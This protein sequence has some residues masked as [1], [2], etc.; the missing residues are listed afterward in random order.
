VLALRPIHVAVD[1]ECLLVAEQ[2]GKTDRPTLAFE[3]VILKYRAT[4]RQRTPLL[5]NPLDVTPQ[6][7]LLRKELVARPAVF[8]ALVRKANPI[9]PRQVGGCGECLVGRHNRSPLVYCGS[10][11]CR[12][13]PAETNIAPL[14]DL[15]FN[16]AT[17]WC[18]VR[19]RPSEM[20]LDFDDLAIPHRQSLSIAE[21]PT[22]LA[23]PFV[24]DEGTFPRRLL[25]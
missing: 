11:A 19:D 13:H 25:N 5:G 16:E 8:V 21:A 12:A 17:L 20:D 14:F 6:F 1:R 24:G 18:P 23:S 9:L 22:I 10:N 3:V 2:L 15:G 4:R 7:N